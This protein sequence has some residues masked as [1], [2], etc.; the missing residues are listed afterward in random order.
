MATMAYP[1]TERPNSRNHSRSRSPHHEQPQQ[2][3]QEFT[4]VSCLG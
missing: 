3:Q 4:M 1:V 2:Q